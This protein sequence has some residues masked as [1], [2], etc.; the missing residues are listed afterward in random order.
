MKV[1]EESTH[2][3]SN[4]RPIHLYT[5]QNK[6]GLELICSNYGGIVKNLYLPFGDDRLDLV[7][8]FDE[9]GQYLE[10]HPYFGAIVGRYA[11][12]IAG[13][14]FRIGQKDYILVRNNGPNHLHGG[15]RGFDKVVWDAEPGDQQLRLTYKSAHMEEGYP[16]NLETT[17]TYYLS[18]D[19]EFII[20]YRATTDQPTHVNLTQHSY[21][22]LNGGLTG[23]LDHKLKILAE[24][25]TPKD[26]HDIPTGQMDPVQGTPLDFRQ[27]KTI[28]RDINQMSNGY[29]HNFVLGS[30]AREP[31]LAATVRDD[32]TRIR[33]EVH[34]SQPGLQ[35]YTGNFLENI[36]GKHGRVYQPRSGFCLEAQ[37]FPDTPNK[38]GFPSTLLQ[39]GE[40][41]QHTTLYK[42]FF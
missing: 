26:K 18:D 14:K 13:G 19:N 37:H 16:G 24:K 5:I 41:Y 22:N 29:D 25:Y 21:F 34:T 38:A 42:F 10:E 1:T 36:R 40:T 4:N 9:I 31:R 33:M 11:N 27:E 2:L 17:V 39:P 12:R 35:F 20:E 15:I 28:G 32:T 7:L 8:G 23:T 3:R 6:N 30:P